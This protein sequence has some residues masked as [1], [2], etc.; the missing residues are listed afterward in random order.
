MAGLVH[1]LD[2]RTKLDRGPS[3]LPEVLD[4][5]VVL[6][7]QELVLLLDLDDSLPLLP[8]RLPVNGPDILFIIGPS[9]LIFLV[10]K[11]GVD[12]EKST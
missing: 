10:E 3:Q 5:C 1:E 11:L 8:H 9:V 2:H 4:V 12:L 7:L 6:L